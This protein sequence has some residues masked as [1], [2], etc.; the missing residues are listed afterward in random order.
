MVTMEELLPHV[1]A[2]GVYVCEDIHGAAN[3]YMAAVQGMANRLDD[4][5]TMVADHVDASRSLVATS[6]GLQ[7]TIRSVC[8]YPYVVVIEKNDAAVSELVAPK[9]GT[10]WDPS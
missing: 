7:S 9:R 8:R 3:S 5:S 4:V 10:Q 6:N 2:G 1:K